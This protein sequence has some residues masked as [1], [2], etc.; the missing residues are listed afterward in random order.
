M[1][2]V[3]VVV[4]VSAMSILTASCRDQTSPSSQQGA[5]RDGGRAPDGAGIAGG[6]GGRGGQAGS[7]PRGGAG[8]AGGAGIGG[9]GG[10][11]GAGGVSD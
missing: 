4:L 3:F 7:G 9:V 5:T 11:G 10:A 6:V 1:K 2:N 8:G